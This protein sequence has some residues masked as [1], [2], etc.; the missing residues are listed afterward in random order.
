MGDRVFGSAHCEVPSAAPSGA[1][2]EEDKPNS[3][4]RVTRISDPAHFRTLLP[5]S[6]DIKLE[7]M[8]VTKE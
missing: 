8:T 5:H 4:L 1:L 3:E 7:D 2:R 6:D